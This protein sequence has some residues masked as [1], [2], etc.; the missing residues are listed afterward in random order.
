[1]E[2]LKEYPR[3]HRMPNML[4]VGD[5]NNGKTSIVKR[6]LS[7]YPGENNPNHARQKLPVL[8]IQAPAVPE[9]RRLYSLLLESLGYPHTNEHPDTL[10][11]RVVQTLPKVGVKLIIIDEIHNVNAGSPK[12]QAVFMNVLRFLQNELPIPIVAVGILD[13]Q[14]TIQA[15]AQLEN[16]FGRPYILARWRA[17]KDF[18]RLLAGFEACLPLQRASNLTE[19]VM[20]GR[21]LALCGGVLGDLSALLQSAAI[22]AVKCGEERISERILDKL[23]WQAPDPRRHTAQTAI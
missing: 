1:M 8:A 17:G 14:Y 22:E 15:D 6:F 19:P 18:L 3:I 20:A 21:L 10:R 12:K 23:G 2:E 7:L 5:T 16:R 9:E 13:A 11:H 4:I